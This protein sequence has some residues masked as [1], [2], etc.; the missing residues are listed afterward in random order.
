MVEETLAG[1]ADR[2]KAYTIATTVFERG[3][4]FD[5]QQDPV[6]RMEA[7][8]LRNALERFY[9]TEG[10][11]GLVKISIPKGRYVPQFESQAPPAGE[12]PGNASAA[13]ARDDYVRSIL[14]KHF[15]VEGDRLAFLGQDQRLTRLIMIGLSRYPGLCV[16][17]PKS[18][19]GYF[20]AADDEPPQAH[21]SA[22][23]ELSGS[24]ERRAS[25]IS[26][27]AVLLESRTG[28]VLWGQKFEPRGEPQ[29]I[30]SIRDDV[31][32]AIVRTLAQ[33]FGVIFNHAAQAASGKDRLALTVAECVMLFHQYRR[34]YRRNL[35]WPAR[36]GL[37][38]AIVSNPE[39]AEALACLSHLYT[40]AHRFGFASR[41][42]PGMLWKQAE[43]LA[44]KAVAVAPDS[45]CGY[46]ALGQVYW[47]RQDVDASLRATRNALALNANAVEVTADLGLHWAL[48]AKWDLALPLLKKASAMNPG[49]GTAHRVG[50]SL[51][52]FVGG[53]FDQAF[54]AA[55][56][57]HGPDV[58]H[59]YVMQAIALS[60]LGRRA[61]A[62]DAVSSIRDIDPHYPHSGPGVL[63]DLSSGNLDPD[64]ADR[65]GEALTDAGL[66]PT[67]R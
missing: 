1:R 42:T 7:R 8:R 27:N 67:H 48:L 40:D 29:S 18:N 65:I 13:P 5:P 44:H 2:I 45:S 20:L 33:P 37:E 66:K 32:N 11:H 14:V 52:H 58:T 34:S 26:V 41:D 12:G 61:D 39:C 25:K 59:G 9:L 23:L 43:A 60:R 47:V 62:A 30:P 19:S 31:A 50:L 6:V 54:A 17:G 36:E 46:S 4:N 16:Y 3:D 28:R 56:E 15:E 51:Y 63:A 21:R 35:Y 38:R 64:L 24:E 10:K 22:D 55:R 57:I 53:R 49:Y